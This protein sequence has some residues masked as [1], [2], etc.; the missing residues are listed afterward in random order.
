MKYEKDD[1]V[2]ALTQ[3]ALWSRYE[4][5]RGGHLLALLR[6]KNEDIF[7]LPLSESTVTRVYE[8]VVMIS[9]LS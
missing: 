6:K 9:P 2:L 4:G 8:N 7:D 1:R 5:K 3:L